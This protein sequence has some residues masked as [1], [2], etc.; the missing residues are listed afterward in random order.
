VKKVEATSGDL[1]AVRNARGGY[2]GTAFYSSK[3]QIA[4]RLVT[5]REE[6][7]DDDFWRRRLETALAFRKKSA[8]NTDAYRW[9]HGE[10]DGLPSLIVDRYGDH[11]VLQTLSQGA[12]KLKAAF[13]RHLIDLA[14]PRG[15]LERNDPKVRSLEGLPL[16][17]DTLFGKVPPSV[18]V[19]LGGLLF[20]A[21]LWEGQ[22]TGLF[23]DQRE[24]HEAAAR[25]AQGRALDVFAYD[26]GFSLYLARVCEEVLAVDLSQGALG[27]L[28]SN[29][30]ANSFDNIK[31]IE[32]NAFDLL[33]ELADRGESF[34]TIVL[35]PPAFAKN[36]AAVPQATRGYKEI[37]LRALKLL[38]SE[39][40]L[41]T[42]TCSYHIRESQFLDIL[43][44]AAAD[45]RA[46]IIL[47]EKRT[48]SRD[49][50][51]L[52]T[53]PE[54]HYLKCLLLQNV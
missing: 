51:I 3:S 18:P 16:V 44:S 31:T 54:T 38:R 23:L 52:L 43:T 37:N 41:I 12:E 48:Q 10:S 53:M 7:V 39:G 4:L 5:T 6:A 27:R 30:E 50:P 36:R 24:N 2:L 8:T 34:D 33:R 42:S 21:D 47:L 26:G 22:K 17:T 11:V 35:D 40:Y 29:A 13:V 14:G 45:A 32:A 46:H 28:R 9:V 15:I 25:Y 1:V 19:R 49:H 20:N